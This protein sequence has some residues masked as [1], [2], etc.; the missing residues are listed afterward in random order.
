LVAILELFARGVLALG[1][2][3]QESIGLDQFFS[4]QWGGRVYGDALIHSR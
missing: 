1:F 3:P 2:T 4:T